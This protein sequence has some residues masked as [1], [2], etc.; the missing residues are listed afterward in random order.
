MPNPQSDQQEI[1]GA[2]SD[3]PQFDITP[4]MQQQMLRRAQQALASGDANGAMRALPPDYTLDQDSGQIREKTF[5]EQ[6]GDTIKFMGQAGAS[7]ASPWLA[8]L[9]GGAS[10]PT[11]EATMNAEQAAVPGLA[12]TAA[13]AAAAAATKGSGV[14][15]A[16]RGA[17]GV[18]GGAKTGIAGTIEKYAVPAV[19]G[20]FNSL[21]ANKRNQDSLQLQESTLDPYRGV[22]HQAQ[23]VGKLDR[24]ATGNF[25][26]SPTA[27]TGRYAH[28]Y[29]PNSP[30]L[31]SDTVRNVAAQAENQVA[32]GTGAEL[33][34]PLPRV[35]AATND[36]AM[37]AL[38]AKL[39]AKAVPG[40]GTDPN[41]PWLA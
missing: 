32:S 1:T 16:V 37:T 27:I 34:Q 9:A 24:M 33:G 17:L 7:F 4:A 5:W 15:G 10:A 31:P 20:V 21:A 25:A 6:H 38:L 12:A 39:K 18:G 26:A 29:Q 8:G 19:S 13:P 14:M 40:R 11:L 36:P 30:W 22:M 3:A 35:N 23:D 28:S 41:S 2:Y